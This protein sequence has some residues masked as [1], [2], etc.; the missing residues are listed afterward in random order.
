MVIEL[1]EEQQKA[2]DAQPI[3]QTIVDPRTNTTYVLVR[4]KVYERMR[5]ILD[6]DFDAG[7][8]FQAQI[9]SAAAAGWSDP[10]MDVYD[11]QEESALQIAQRAEII[12]CAKG[13]PADLSANKDHFQ[14]IG[15]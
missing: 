13:L 3:P 11:Q 1:T 5:K 14:E 4:I 15:R 7:D 8:A 12:G 6:A 10:A 2:F 9:E